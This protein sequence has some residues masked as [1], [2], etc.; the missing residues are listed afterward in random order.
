[1]IDFD[2]ITTTKAAYGTHV[3]EDIHHNSLA[4]A[5]RLIPRL[6]RAIDRFNARNTLK[7]IDL[8]GLPDEVLLLIVEHIEDVNTL[9]RLAR[10]CRRLQSM[11]ESKIYRS[12]LIRSGPT[13]QRVARSVDKRPARA[14]AMEVL[15]VACKKGL[16][17][18]LI[19]VPEI[20]RAAVQL[21]EYYFAS[22]QC[23]T[24]DERTW[25]TFE[26]WKSLW[27]HV[28][29]PLREAINT[30]SSATLRPSSLQHLQKRRLS[31]QAA[32]SEVSA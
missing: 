26:G 22:P 8:S 2:L 32:T 20:L 21:R 5:M 14:V 1:M 18:N 28:F 24:L 23:N 12:V 15:E 30:A 19:I 17:Q 16:P 9:L 13:A 4:F 27:L 10:T 29:G 25:E 6:S 31:G 7:Q 3:S 11:A